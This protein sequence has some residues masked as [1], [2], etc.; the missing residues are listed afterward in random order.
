MSNKSRIETILKCLSNLRM[1]NRLGYFYYVDKNHDIQMK[2]ARK[3]RI[4]LSK[5]RFNTYKDDLNNFDI[6]TDC[7]PIEKK[8]TNVDT[9]SVG[10]SSDKEKKSSIVGESE[11]LVESEDG[12]YN[13]NNKKRVEKN[14]YACKNDALYINQITTEKTRKL[15]KVTNTQIGNSTTAIN[16]SNYVV[17]N[18]SNDLDVVNENG[19]DEKKQFEND[20]KDMGMNF[21]VLSSTVMI[22]RIDATGGEIHPNNFK[23]YGDNEG[24]LDLANKYFTFDGTNNIPTPHFHFNTRNQSIQLSH[25]ESANAIYIDNLISYLTDLYLMKLEE[26]DSIKNGYTD[27]RVDNLLLEDMGMP[28]LKIIDCDNLIIDKTLMPVEYIENTKNHDAIKFMK[29]LSMVNTGDNKANDKNKISITG[30]NYIY[31]LITIL[32]QYRNVLLNANNNSTNSLNNSQIAGITNIV[33]N[34]VTIGMQRTRQRTL[35]MGD[36]SDNENNEIDMAEYMFYLRRLY[37]MGYISIQELTYKAKNVS[38]YE[39]KRLR[40]DYQDASENT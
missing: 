22:N 23:I 35:T 36:D 31:K 7:Y 14:I 29:L 15:D 33:S 10:K 25:Q 27:Y 39:L 18:F 34:F 6:F 19:K 28:F 40:K 11:E 20:Y 2:Q 32:K 3:Q 38:L 17:V 12:L 9:I 26:N 16:V 21:I 37:K 13:I 30:M 5:D 1:K 4:V 24:K 8:L